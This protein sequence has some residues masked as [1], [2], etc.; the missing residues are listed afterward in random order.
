MY[1]N[2]IVSKIPYAHD[3]IWQKQ[4][5][6]WPSAEGILNCAGKVEHNYQQ[7]YLRLSICCLLSLLCITVS[8]GDDRDCVIDLD[9]MAVSMYYVY[10]LPP[11]LHL[12]LVGF[13]PN[14]SYKICYISVALAHIPLY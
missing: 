10:S 8:P 6:C 14:E 9:L 1:S 13:T 3:I 5:Q 2:N 4:C 12:L 7:Y 11:L